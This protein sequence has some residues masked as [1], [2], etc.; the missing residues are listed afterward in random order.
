MKVIIAGSRLIEGY[1]GRRLVLEAIRDCGFEITEIV[2][3]G[4]RGIDRSAEEVAG[5]KKIPTK[6]M[7]VLPREW[8][9]LGKRAGP[10]R[11]G[12]MAEYADALIAIPCPK[13][14]GTL[15]MIEK[16]KALGKPVYVHPEDRLP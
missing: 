13:S 9:L 16:M 6:R 3:G 2:S 4:C 10:L 8:S 14:K 12:R 11:N 15:D 5:F 1:H 7:P